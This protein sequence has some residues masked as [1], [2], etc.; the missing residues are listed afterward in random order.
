MTE[1]KSFSWVVILVIAV[2]WLILS[3]L[4][5][6]EKGMRDLRKQL[7]MIALDAEEGGNR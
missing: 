7:L 6:M 5:R 3:R 2:T 4:E 1:E